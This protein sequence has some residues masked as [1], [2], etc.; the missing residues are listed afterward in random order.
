MFS[1]PL[2]RRWGFYFLREKETSPAQQSQH[3]DKVARIV[4]IPALQNFLL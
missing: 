4:Y 3:I 2:P 1:R